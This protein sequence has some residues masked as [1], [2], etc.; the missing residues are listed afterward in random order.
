MF[1]MIEPWWL[2]AVA[3]RTVSFLG[4]Q[5]LHN[6]TGI[7]TYFVMRTDSWNA[8][9]RVISINA[10]STYTMIMR[11]GGFHAATSLRSWP[12]LRRRALLQKRSYKV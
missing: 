9:R 12:C 8:K 11:T 1:G 5:S 4:L 10:L 2:H 7:D 6:F 3:T